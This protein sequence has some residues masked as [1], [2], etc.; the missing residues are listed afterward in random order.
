VLTGYFANA[1]QIAVSADFIG[2]LLTRMPALYLLCDP[3]LGDDDELY[4]KEEVAIAIRDRL[5]PMAHGLAPNTFEAGWL[6]GVTIR[7]QGD[8]ETAARYWPQKDVIITSIPDRSDHVST[9]VFSRY[10]NSVATRPRLKQVPHGTGDFLSG[11]F[12]GYLARG[13]SA[14]SAL[15]QAMERLDRVIAASHGSECLDLARGLKS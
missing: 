15:P 10:G 8:A 5:V 11:L 1:E 3:V 9:A 14:H 2:A 13:V 7:N 4:V 12:A 6:S